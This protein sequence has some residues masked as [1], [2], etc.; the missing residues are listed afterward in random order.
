M[1]RV[2]AL[3][4]AACLAL[5][6]LALSAG[7]AAAANGELGGG[8]IELLL[9]GSAGPTKFVA[10]PGDVVADRAGP[11]AGA[12]GS[13]RRRAAGRG[14]DARRARGG[15]GG[16]VPPPGGRLFRPRGARHDRHRHAAEVPVPG[17][18]GRT[19]DPLRRR[20]RPARLRMVGGQDDHPQGRMAGL[21]AAAAD[22]AAPARPARPYGRRAGQ[23]ARRAR[24]LSRLVAL[25]HSRHQRAGDDRPRRLVRLH[26]D[27]ERGRDRPLQPRPGR[28]EGHRHLRRAA[29]ATSDVE[30]AARAAVVEAAAVL[31]GVV[32]RRVLEAAE[33]TPASGSAAST[34]PASGFGAS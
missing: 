8:F 6:A 10:P 33:S 31:A 28:H 7:G 19:G 3:P 29:G 5:S 15:A 20:R 14:A 30:A 21:D 18:A 26:P 12:N 13:A 27:D 4:V 23:S 25:P 9:T 16:G 1:R 24:A 17:R 34:T 2:P 22:D 32:I 11:G